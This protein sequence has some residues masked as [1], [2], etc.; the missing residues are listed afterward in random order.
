MKRFNKQALIEAAINLEELFARYAT[1]SDDVARAYEQCKALIG[2][3]Q[4]GAIDSPSSERLPAGYFSTEFDLID[5]RDLY[6]AASLFNM[7]LEGWESEEAYNTHVT[8]LLDK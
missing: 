3:A 7:Y 8:E 1:E 5:F 4:S 6:H 2:T